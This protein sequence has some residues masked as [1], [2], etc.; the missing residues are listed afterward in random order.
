[1]IVAQMSAS[2]DQF[3][4]LQLT[5]Y[6][7]SAGMG[8]RAPG[9]GPQE[10]AASYE[11]ELA[12]LLER[13]DQNSTAMQKTAI[14]AIGRVLAR[15]QKSSFNKL[16]G[17]PFDTSALEPGNRKAAGSLRPGDAPVELAPIN[18]GDAPRVQT[19]PSKK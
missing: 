14:R 4:D 2:R 16:L 5:Q 7:N 3:L 15:R 17:E 13:I 6:E 19:P 10:P 18:P 8:R 12:S 9:A 1:M 11:Q